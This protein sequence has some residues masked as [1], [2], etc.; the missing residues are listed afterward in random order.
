MPKTRHYHATAATYAA[1][2]S[3]NMYTVAHEWQELIDE[4]KVCAHCQCS[5][6]TVLEPIPGMSIK[7]K[8]H[9]FRDKNGRPTYEW[10]EWQSPVL[11]VC[12]PRKVT[13]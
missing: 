10:A 9:I 6:Q 1:R 3:E 12:I 11:P 7:Y 4:W 2:V 5:V 8:Y 13:K